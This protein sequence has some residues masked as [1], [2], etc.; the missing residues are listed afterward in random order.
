V[1][2]DALRVLRDIFRIRRW[3]S[4]GVYDLTPAEQEQ[5]APG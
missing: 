1:G 5:M 4:R 3:A 2:L